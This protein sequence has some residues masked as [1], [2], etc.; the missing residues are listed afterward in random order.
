[1]NRCHQ[2]EDRDVGSYPGKGIG[3]FKTLVTGRSKIHQRTERKL[4]RLQLPGDRGRK[5]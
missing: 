5:E 2:N 1:M 3:T 4:A